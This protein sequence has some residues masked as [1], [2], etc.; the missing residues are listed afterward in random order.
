LASDALNFFDHLPC[1][2]ETLT[3]VDS[4]PKFQIKG[5]ILLIAPHEPGHD[6]A[7]LAPVSVGFL[8]IRIL[9]ERI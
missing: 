1:C 6:D 3:S 5:A 8:G 7:F 4:L 9:H 2:R